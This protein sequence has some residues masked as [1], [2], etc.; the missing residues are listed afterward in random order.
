MASVEAIPEKE[1]V[2]RVSD[3]EEKGEL[4]AHVYIDPVKEKKLMW[5]VDLRV[6]PPLTILFLLA[7][8]DRTNIGTYARNCNIATMTDNAR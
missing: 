3:V 4:P 6:L 7:F 2:S 8:L 1:G 5:K